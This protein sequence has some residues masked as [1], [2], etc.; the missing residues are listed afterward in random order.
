MKKRIWKMMWSYF[1]SFKIQA[2]HLMCFCIS[3]NRQR[4]KLVYK[5]RFCFVKIL[6]VKLSTECYCVFVIQNHMLQGLGNTLISNISSSL[7]SLLYEFSGLFHTSRKWKETVQQ[8]VII[9]QYILSNSLHF[10]MTK[11]FNFVMFMYS[12]KHLTIRSSSNMS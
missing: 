7:F 2:I 4:K 11:H 5:S 9:R 12:W 8:F 3:T 1:D 10:S 6:H